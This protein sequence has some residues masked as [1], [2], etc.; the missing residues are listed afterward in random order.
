MKIY[1]NSLTKI[2]QGECN[3][4]LNEIEDETIDLIFADPP[5]NIGKKFGKFE[6]KW[7]SEKE[8]IEWY[9]TWLELC[10]KKLKPSGSLYLMTSTQALPYIDIWLRKKMTILSRI[11]WYYDSSGVQAKKYFGSLY[12]PIL[13]AVKNCKN[14]TFNSS[15]IE[16][17]AKTGSQ[18]KLIDYRKKIPELYKSKK[19]PGNV[20]YIPRVRYRMEEYEEHPSQKPEKLLERIIKAS[21]NIGDTILDPFGG[22]FTTSAV[23]QKLGRKSISIEMEKDYFKIGLRRLKLTT[24]YNN[25]ELKQPNKVFV[26]KYESVN[27]DVQITL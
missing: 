12:E 18:R 21:T 24:H 22:T 20:W 8:Y 13:F 9:C 11:V 10:I 1:E 26:K 23:A 15:D 3:V 16:I 25:T 19:T 7:N 6:D 4:I 5:Y 17:E 2:Y 27:V 14:Y